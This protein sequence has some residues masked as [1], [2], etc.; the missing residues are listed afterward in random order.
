MNES[1]LVSANFTKAHFD[2]LRS[3]LNIPQDPPSSVINHT[4]TMRLACVRLTLR[5]CT[6]SIYMRYFHL[7]T[8][9][10][11]LSEGLWGLMVS[12]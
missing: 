4:Y 2:T 11:V 9:S 5:M 6:S 1:K 10:H 3:C 12:W 7:S 8:T